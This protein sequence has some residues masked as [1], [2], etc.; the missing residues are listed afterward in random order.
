MKR[1]EIQN[2]KLSNEFPRMSLTINIF[3]DGLPLIFHLQHDYHHVSC[4][5]FNIL[6][7]AV[8]ETE[9]RWPYS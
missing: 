1:I 4:H 6:G 7:T 8:L 3:L 2:W 9:S 5:V